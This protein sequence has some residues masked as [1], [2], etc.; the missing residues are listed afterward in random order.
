MAGQ[1]FGIKEVDDGR[2]LITFVAHDL[3]YIDP[4]QKTLKTID[5]PFGK[6]V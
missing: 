6:N 5:I 2:W 3:G 4:E 1:K